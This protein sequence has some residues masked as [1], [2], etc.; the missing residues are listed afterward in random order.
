MGNRFTSFVWGFALILLG[1]LYAGNVFGMWDFNL[2][3][4]GWWSLF[5]IVPCTAGLFRRGFRYGS[6]IGLVIGIILLLVAQDYITFAMVMKLLL[7]I[8]LV[9][10]GI[11]VLYVAFF[12]SKKKRYRELNTNELSSY[13]VVFGG[14]EIKYPYEV[15][16]GANITAIVAGVDLDLRGSIINQDV[17]INCTTICAGVEII[18]PPNVNVQFMGTPILGG[19]T[20][21]RKYIPQ[22]GEYT[23][24]IKGNIICGGIDI[25]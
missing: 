23:I 8:I 22:E 14:R 10:V 19:I 2:F 13:S 9:L 25:K 7:P 20:D 18:V 12:D 17:V 6:F 21:D 1:V 5:I 3:F 16:K 24:Y 15:F 4:D 11:R